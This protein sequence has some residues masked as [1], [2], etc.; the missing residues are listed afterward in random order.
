MSENFYYALNFIAIDNK[1]LLGFKMTKT[2]NGYELKLKD[3]IPFK[4]TIT[5]VVYDPEGH[6]GYILKMD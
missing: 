1:Q 2:S 6:Y 3:A 4:H 5:N